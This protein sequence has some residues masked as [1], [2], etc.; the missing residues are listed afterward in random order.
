MILPQGKPEFLRKVID[1]KDAC[2]V[3]APRRAAMCRAFNQWV[4]TG[5]EGG[6]RALVNKLYSHNERLAAHLYSPTE[7]RFD[8][9]FESHY[10]TD[11]LA[12]GETT[13]RVITR[14]WERKDIDMLFGDGVNLGL[15][16][17]A[18]IAKQVW[19]HAGVEARLVMPW[20]FGVY[21]EDVTNLEDQEALCESGLMT[22][23]EVWRRISHLKDAESMYRRILAH[24]EKNGG[25]VLNN[26][27][28]HN[29]LSSNVLNTDLA[30]QRQQ[31]GG[32]VQL[33]D[34]NAAGMLAP[35]I[36]ID[37]VQYHELYIKDD[38]TEDYVTILLIEPDILVSPRL[39]RENQFAPK[40]QPFSLI[41]PNSA[42][43]YLWGRP[44]ATDLIAPQGLLAQWFNDVRRMQ[45]IQVDKILA[46]TGADGITDERYAQFRE[47]G[48]IDLPAG[49]SVN[50]L[51]PQFP[52]QM[53][54]S[55]EVLTRF[56]DEISGF[57]NILSGQGEPGVRAG[58]QADTM[59]KMASPRL[60]DRAL[61]VE[62][63]CAAMA[64]KTLDLLQ[65]KDGRPYVTDKTTGVAKEFL[66]YDLPED[67]RITV[68]S[69][70]SSPIF[71]DDHQQ[72]VAFGLK[73]GFIGGDSAIEQLPYPRKDL[74]KQ[75]YKAM[76]DAKQKMIQEHPEILTHQKPKH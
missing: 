1:I 7:L 18:A 50:D 40:V 35:E 32:I 41:Q 56:M 68:D 20:C 12:M 36:A 58:N 43:D 28:F 5:T 21:R 11:I 39:K 54:Q 73:A 44:E 64:D 60:R 8:M 55:I 49:A 19:G 31:P 42:P 30:T 48:Y 46:F 72:L 3:S 63:Q 37:L 27:F 57:G 51:T 76:Q 6:N 74:L 10:A 38:A 22:L 61:L 13:A 29:V 62:R 53:F 16:Y 45:G 70:S 69:H 59:V 67:R 34:V 52:P 4:E 17:G 25:D 71:A 2:R 14:E 23:A 26:S 33:A 65:A 9:D 75:R 47:A 24:A 15:K 66:L